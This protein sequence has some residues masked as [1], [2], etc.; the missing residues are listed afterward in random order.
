MIHNFEELTSIENIF[1]AW[2]E[3]RKGKKKRKDVQIFERNLEDNLFALYFTLK[4]E[5]Y[6]HGDYHAFYVHDPKR[7]HIHKASVRDRIVHHLLYKYLYEIYDKNFIYD[8]YSCRLEK[9][10]HKAV[11]RMERFARK[12]S[13]NY[14]GLCWVLKLDIKKFFANVDHQILL[15]LLKRKIK[16]PNILWLLKNVIDSFNSEL[17]EGKGIPLGNLTSQIFANIYMNEL[18]QFIK[19]QLRV[20][21][22]IR[23]ADDFIFLSDSVVE[24]KKYIIPLK[25]FLLKSLKLELHPS[26]IIFRRLDWGIDFLG[27]IVLPH[28]ILPRTKTKRR[29]FKKLEEKRNSKNFNQTIQSYLGYLKHARAYKLRRE[30]LRSFATPR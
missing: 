25:E 3:F 8:S 16:D 21:Y 12:V 20:K 14:I 29:M 11:K 15:D 4:N 28:Y 19:H 1:Q 27:Y 18:D 13:R 22:Y 30:I 5:T 6:Q 24:L 17:R 23:Y 9:G 10:T 26:K 2:S 7:R